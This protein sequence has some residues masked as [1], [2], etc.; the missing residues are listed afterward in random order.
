M[1]RSHVGWLFSDGNLA[2]SFVWTET[3]DVARDGS[4]YR[5][6]NY[7]RLYDVNGVQ[8]GEGPGTASAT[9]IPAP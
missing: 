8:I 2:G 5:G 7:I 1:R 3:D 9:R 6:K 4:W